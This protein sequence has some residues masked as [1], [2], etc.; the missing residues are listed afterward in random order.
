MGKR[1]T[2]EQIEKMIDLWKDRWST[3][4]ILERSLEYKGNSSRIKFVLYDSLFALTQA[5]FSWIIIF[6]YLCN[7]NELFLCGSE[8]NSIGY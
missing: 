7:V 3:K 2:E 6:N 5:L 8:N 1:V 4:A